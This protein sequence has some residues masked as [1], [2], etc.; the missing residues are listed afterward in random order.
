MEAVLAIL[1]VLLTLGCVGY[2]VVKP[3]YA[4]VPVLMLFPA[5]QIL[6]GYLP[7]F[8]WQYGWL[9]NTVVGLVALFGVAY[10]FFRG[11][12]VFRGMNNHVF[13]ALMALYLYIMCSFLWTP[14]PASAAFF[15]KNN[16]AYFFLFYL[17]TPLLTKD[18]DDLTSINV[19]LIVSGVVIMALMLI[20]PRARFVDDRFTIDLGYV[21]GIGTLRSNPLAIADAG[22]MLAIIAAIYRPNGVKPLLTAL[23]WAGVLLGLTL[24]LLSGSR[25]QVLASVAVIAV[26]LPFAT[27]ARSALRVAGSVLTVGVI[28]MFLYYAFQTFVISE[29][30]GRYSV[31]GSRQGLEQR[32]DMVLTLLGAYA[33]SPAFWPTGLGASAFN[34]HYVFRTAENP[35]WYPHNIFAE[36]IGEYGVPGIVLLCA[37]CYYTFRNVVKLARLAGD[38][39]ARRTTVIVFAGITVFHFLMALKQGSLLGMP[40]FFMF[41]AILAR[42]TKNEEAAALASDE[43]LGDGPMLDAETVDDEWSGDAEPR[44]A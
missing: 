23:K 30:Q 24:A 2:C 32:M 17:V 9:T 31:E 28:V 16:W 15:L 10:N 33:Q 20:N 41:C 43:Q 1:V 39:R 4:I 35:H 26:L 22:G 25:G 34:E 42:V 18:L 12:G 29:A 3:R 36:A 7:E 40:L 37:I 44:P 19:P 38:D 14:S 27:G 6:M 13:Y 21:I 11:S 8:R 5:E